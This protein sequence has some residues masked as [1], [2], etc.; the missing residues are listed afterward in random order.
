MIGTYGKKP[1]VIE[2]NGETPPV[3]PPPKI[4]EVKK[5]TVRERLTDYGKRRVQK[6]VE[7]ME[8]IKGRR[9]EEQEPTGNN[10]E[11]EVEGV[12]V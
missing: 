8:V 5:P 4:N 6:R 7:D 11:D 3:I 2:T 1:P 10:D 9:E 12:G